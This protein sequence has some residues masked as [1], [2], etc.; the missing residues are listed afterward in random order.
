MSVKCNRCGAGCCL[1]SGC[2][3]STY[4]DGLCPSCQKD[5]KQIEELKQ[6][7]EVNA[8]NINNNTV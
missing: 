8:V 6:K 1:C 7:Q 2:D 4:K 3:P 5:L